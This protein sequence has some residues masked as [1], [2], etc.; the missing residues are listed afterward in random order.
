MQANAFFGMHGIKVESLDLQPAE[1]SDLAVTTM[2]ALSGDGASTVKVIIVTGRTGGS[3]DTDPIV[4]QSKQVGSG[5]KKTLKSSGVA[6][7]DAAGTPLAPCGT[8]SMR[9]T[10][11]NLS[12]IQK[13]LHQARA[14]HVICTMGP[15]CWSEEGMRQLL[16]A[17]C[18]IIRLNFSHGEH[19]GAVQRL[20]SGNHALIYACRCVW[21][22]WSVDGTLTKPQKCR[23]LG[24]SA[25]IPKG[26]C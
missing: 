10:T 2:R 22:A 20:L 16:D 15:A 17:G 24:N 4:Q 3:A 8:R 21:F 11:T 23:A 19:A 14:T 6:L 7:T 26:C 1:L 9:S 13:P 18:D 25:A 5:M 12:L